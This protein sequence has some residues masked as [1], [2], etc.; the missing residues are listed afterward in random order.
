MLSFPYEQLTGAD[1]AVPPSVCHV[2]LHSPFWY[3]RTRV[4]PSDQTPKTSTRP[5]RI[6]AEEGA[7]RKDPPRDCHEVV[8]QAWDT[9]DEE[10]LSTRVMI[11]RYQMAESAPRTK[12]KVEEVVVVVVVVPVLSVVLAVVRVVE[13][14]AMACG[15]T[16]PRQ[17]EGVWSEV[18]KVVGR[19]KMDWASGWVVLGFG[20]GGG[21]MSVFLLASV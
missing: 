20:E 10:E 6:S 14:E 7:D 3:V 19:P 1:P 9:E 11:W 13:V 17:R 8:F 4:V 15:Q 5:G 18:G 21:V 2:S 12:R 16:V